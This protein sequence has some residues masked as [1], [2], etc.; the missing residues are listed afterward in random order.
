MNFTWKDVAGLIG[1]AAPLI[2][3]MLGGPLGA[4]VG[5]VVASALGVKDDPESAY[6]ALEA[7]PDLLVEIKKAEMENKRALVEMHLRA[8]TAI[9]DSVNETIRSEVASNDPFVRRARPAMLYAIIAILLAQT[10]AGIAAIFFLQGD[11][12]LKAKD[13]ILALAAPLDVGLAV[14]GVYVYRRS[15]DKQLAAGY[16]AQGIGGVLGAVLG[17]GSK[18]GGA[19]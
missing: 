14:C 18:P 15:T 2:G 12:I 16:P 5:T 11:D 19:Q 10:A 4:R 3:G 8:D 13:M 9:I 6:K 1:D 17:K 7:N